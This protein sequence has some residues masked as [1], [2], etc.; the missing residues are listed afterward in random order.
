MPTNPPPLEQSASRPADFSDPYLSN[1]DFSLS[2]NPNKISKQL[3]APISGIQP[4]LLSTAAPTTP[5]PMP[6]ILAMSGLKRMDTDTV[7]SPPTFAFT[8]YTS[9]SNS[10]NSLIDSFVV[11]DFT[12]FNPYIHYYQKQTAPVLGST[13]LV[14]VQ[15]SAQIALA[16]QR[17]NIYSRS[18]RTY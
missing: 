14:I 10:V 3:I 7:S 4:G 16:T 11:T 9:L 12:I 6:S 1:V 15:P 8:N 17:F 2:T 18:Y 13:D 5:A